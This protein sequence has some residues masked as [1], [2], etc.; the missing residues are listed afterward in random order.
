MPTNAVLEDQV[1]RTVYRESTL[2][3]SGAAFDRMIREGHGPAFL[4]SN[5]SAMQ[6]AVMT[7]IHRQFRDRDGAGVREALQD[8]GFEN[9]EIY[10]MDLGSGE[11]RSNHQGGVIVDTTIMPPLMLA[12]AAGTNADDWGT[13]AADAPSF[14]GGVLGMQTTLGAYEQNATRY[15]RAVMAQDGGRVNTLSEIYQQLQEHYPGQ[16][17]V[18]IFS[19]ASYGADVMSRMAVDFAEEFPEQRG[20]IALINFGPASSLNRR[21]REEITAVTDPHRTYYYGLQGDLIPQGADLNRVHQPVGREEII[22]M[23]RAGMFGLA[24][25][26]SYYEALSLNAVSAYLLQRVRAG[27]EDYVRQRLEEFR[28]NRTEALSAIMVDMSEYCREP[29]DREIQRLERIAQA[30]RSGV[31]GV[32]YSPEYETTS[33]PTVLTDR[34][35]AAIASLGSLVNAGTNGVPQEGMPITGIVVSPV[36][37]TQLT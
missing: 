6:E 26:N 28:E 37:E 20:R 29:F 17:I 31:V 18:P 2:D 9:L 13:H 21:E 30:G 5:N 16:N 34:D 12:F 35:R 23:S 15:E 10:N 7:W 4:R 27:D 32:S 24:T 33:T 1:R 14:L 36:A 11:S 8:A 22:P 19:G 3:A 25:H